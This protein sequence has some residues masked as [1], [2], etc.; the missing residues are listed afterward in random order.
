M[1]DEK[2]SNMEVVEVDAFAPVPR[3]KADKI[4]SGRLS[5]WEEEGACVFQANKE[6]PEL[7]REI[8]HDKGGV[9]LSK[10]Q[11]EKESSIILTAKVDADSPDPVGDL[12]CKAYDQLKG[13][14]KKVPQIP[15]ANFL[16]DDPDRLRV[17]QRKDKKQLCLF[18]TIDISR[19]KA[20]IINDNL[21]I[22][23]KVNRL[24]Q[25]EF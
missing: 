11:G 10:T 8:L 6:R 22:M 24:I 21:E 19:D 13:K 7:K 4:V 3:R 14:A 23:A 16:I 17:W 18:A 15:S 9:R 5:T 1:K 2:N 20:F 12:L 25:R